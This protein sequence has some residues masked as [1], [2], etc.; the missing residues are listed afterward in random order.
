MQVTR[1]LKTDEKTLYRFIQ[2]LADVDAKQPAKKGTVYKKMLVNVNGVKQKVKV[3]VN[4]MQPGLYQVTIEQGQNTYL[5]RY[6]WKAA[7]KGKVELVYEETADLK[8]G[9]GKLNQK[10]TAFLTSFSTKRRLNDRLDLF[11]KAL[12][13]FDPAD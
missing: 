3:T 13:G 6:S 2:S 4:A 8:S 1:T 11:E 12:E 9:G 7:G 10:L 5:M